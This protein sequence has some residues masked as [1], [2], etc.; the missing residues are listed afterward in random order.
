MKWA[1][2]VPDF[3]KKKHKVKPASRT[4]AD[5]TDEFTE[6]PEE[7]VKSEAE[8][9]AEEE[10]EKD[11]AELGVS[12]KQKEEFMEQNHQLNLKDLGNWLPDKVIES[13]KEDLYCRLYRLDDVDG[14]LK[15]NPIELPKDGVDIFPIG[16][17]LLE[18]TA[19]T[20]GPGRFYF[21]IWDKKRCCSVYNAPMPFSEDAKPLVE[22]K[23]KKIDKVDELRGEM[24]E[25]FDKIVEMMKTKG[26]LTFEQ[27]LIL[28]LI[29]DSGKKGG[30]DLNES[31]MTAFASV[32]S[33]EIKSGADVRK[34]EIDSTTE[35]AKMKM[36]IEKAK[37]GIAETLGEIPD[38]F[39]T[40]EEAEE[41]LGKVV[42]GV[43]KFVEG[44]SSFMNNLSNVIEKA[45]K[46]G[47]QGQQG[48][49]EEDIQ[50]T[51]DKIAGETMSE[52][53]GE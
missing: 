23:I 49:A 45:Q 3:L 35:L 41:G 51:A 27:Q 34:T 46:P 1:N 52:G 12:D 28:K 40:K 24:T 47:Q 19:L 5:Y 11:I 10:L 43:N 36:E 2:L 20:T 21:R 22:E 33:Q 42:N 31:L 4:D 8:Q 18:M 15:W 38:E 53:E 39:K 6:L 32:K 25:S 17:D 50:A 48:S 9:L 13:K 44:M 7:E 26:G 16:L 14:K 29:S 37:I 30:S